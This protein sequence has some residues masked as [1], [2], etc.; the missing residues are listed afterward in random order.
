MRSC[1]GSSR[2]SGTASSKLEQGQARVG[3][4]EERVDFAE[5]LLAQGREPNRLGAEGGHRA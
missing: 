3:E 4:L 5:R 1:R 2:H